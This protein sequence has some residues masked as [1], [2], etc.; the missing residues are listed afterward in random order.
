MIAICLL[1]LPTL[2]IMALLNCTSPG[3]EQSLVLLPAS[4][5]HGLALASVYDLTDHFQSTSQHL[6]KSIWINSQ[7]RCSEAV[8][9]CSTKI[10]IFYICYACFMQLFCN[11]IKKAIEFFWQVLVSINHSAYSSWLYEAAQEN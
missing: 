4:S 11:S 9:K 7:L 5:D 6:A 1:A 10:Q 2:S 3:A 8:S